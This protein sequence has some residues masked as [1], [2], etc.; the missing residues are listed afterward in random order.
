M[1]DAWELIHGLSPSSPADALIDSDGDGSINLVE[2]WFGTDPRSSASRPQL[3]VGLVAGSPRIQWTGLMEKRYQP[4][5]T[6]DLAPGAW[7]ALGDPQT[8]AGATLQA[9]DA[10]ATL[11]G[12]RFYRLRVL[13]SFD[14]DGDGLDDWLE[15]AVYATNP[16]RG[17]SSGAGI[18]DG[19]AVR[20]GLNPATVSPT[21]DPDG[22]GASNLAEYLRGTDPLVA[23]PPSGDAVASLRVF[24]PMGS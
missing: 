2:Y 10:V 13:P 23:D 7:T 12:R 20:F 17:S 21:A 19:W 4:E 6:A 1:D 14:R 22:D 18:P 3:A 9:D 8:G 16:N 11:P 5:F 24:T 15:S